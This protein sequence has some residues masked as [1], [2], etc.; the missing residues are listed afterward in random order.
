MEQINDLFNAFVP[1]WFEKDEAV[2]KEKTAKYFAE[3]V[4]ALFTKFNMRLGMEGREF[5]IGDGLTAV[6]LQVMAICDTFKS[7]VPEETFVANL[8]NLA[9]HLAKVR[10][11][12]AVVAHNKRCNEK[13]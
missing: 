7:V 11:L 5:F 1:V 4:P 6:D 9:N 2:K 13:K 3:N 8:P 10:A 12:P